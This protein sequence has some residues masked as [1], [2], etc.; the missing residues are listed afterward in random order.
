MTE[1][2]P[3]TGH[4]RLRAAHRLPSFAG[5]GLSER[6]RSTAFSLLGLTAAAGL[7][8]VALFAQPGWP[9]LEPAPLP[10][11]PT[12]SESVAEA[13]RVGLGGGFGELASLR[14]APRFERG[15]TVADRRAAVPGEGVAVD[16]PAGGVD[17]AEGVASPPPAGTPP[18][19]GGEDAG[20]PTPVPLPAP[21]PGQAPP[22]SPSPVAGPG[23]EGA[24]VSRGGGSTRTPVVAAT[25][26]TPAAPGH[27]SSSAA[28]SHASDRGVES[29]AKHAAP[30]PAAPPP[31]A[32][33]MP[34]P[35]PPGPPP[36]PGQGNGLA[37]GHD[38]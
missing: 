37:K 28:A 9:L 25:P 12:R 19:S 22:A 24:P 16:A 18:A 20:A 34:E 29:S 33:P 1:M 7:A 21:T 35:S 10:D 8:L 30:S 11:Q 2:V 14:P 4:S 3:P 27:S 15:T 6:M 38:K 5:Q 13:E 36:D 17:P 31:T 26:P 32:V 23:S